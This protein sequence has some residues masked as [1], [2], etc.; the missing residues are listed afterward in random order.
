M[1]YSPRFVFIHIP[2]TGGISITSALAASAP[3]SCVHIENHRHDYAW[4]IRHRLGTECWNRK[5]VFSMIRSPWEI[6]ASSYRLAKR[7]VAAMKVDQHFA[8]M[9]NTW[10]RYLRT[11]EVDMDFGTYVKRDILSGI[12][13]VAQGGFWR[14]WCCDAIDGADLGVTAYLYDRLEIDWPI[15]AARCGVPDA[16]LPRLNT[17]DPEPAPWTDELVA[18]VGDLCK[19]DILRFHFSPP[20]IESSP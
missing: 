11:F 4:I 18:K 5:F 19:D 1:I 9:D 8:A 3:Q 6:I 2:R 14:T 7:D 16:H 10:T 20:S 13:G 12:T 17:T 15:I